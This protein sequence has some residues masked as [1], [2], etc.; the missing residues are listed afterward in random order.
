MMRFLALSARCLAKIHAMRKSGSRR[1]VEIHAQ[2]NRFRYTVAITVRARI[3][4][5][6]GVAP[7]RST[8]AS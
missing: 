5:L 7:I 4:K 8:S 2:V 1:H 6:P 3:L